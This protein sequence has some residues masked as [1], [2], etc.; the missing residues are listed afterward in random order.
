MAANKQSLG[1][2]L[3]RSD[4]SAFAELYDACA[5]SLH[6][7]LTARLESGDRAADV[8]Q[9]V[10][11]RAVQNRKRFATVE[12]PIAYLFQ[13]AR[14]EAARAGERAQRQQAGRLTTEAFEQTTEDRIALDDTELA[15]AAL[16]K[17]DPEQRELI[18]LKTFAGLTYAEIAQV[19]GQPAATVATRYRRAVESL[20]PWLER[21]FDLP[22]RE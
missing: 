17:L 22:R 2:R 7:Y 21:Q 12:N 14:N 6:R 11:V 10:F 13:I 16:A 20:R 5:D 3:A 18:E 4:E 9:T 15:A 19:T 8:L 1:V